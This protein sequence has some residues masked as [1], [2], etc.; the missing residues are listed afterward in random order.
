MKKKTCNI[1]L[2]VLSLVIIFIGLGGFLVYDKFKKENNFN[3]IQNV[4]NK[5]YKEFLD[6]LK[7]ERKE[8]IILKS[9]DDYD[10]GYEIRLTNEGEVIA[11]VKAS[12]VGIEDIDNQVIEANVLEAFV[13]KVGVGD[14]GDNRELIFIKENGDVTSISLGK[15]LINCEIKINDYKSLNQIVDVYDRVTISAS[16]YEPA[17][18]SVYVKNIKEEEI[19]ITELISQNRY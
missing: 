6:K 18:Y 13:V 11:N 19:D 2:I 10:D 8:Q 12:T 7:R 17:R 3:E 14:V 15:L 5:D 16:L 1:K 9:N 4:E